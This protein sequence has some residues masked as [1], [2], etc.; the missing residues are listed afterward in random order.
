[1]DT[2]DRL[3]ANLGMLSSN[4]HELDKL[5]KIIDIEPLFM[6]AF[7]Q[8]CDK[9]VPKDI[10]S[11]ISHGFW[12]A[13]KINYRKMEEFGK[14]ISTILAFTK[15]LGVLTQCDLNGFGLNE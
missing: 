9:K 10:L 4:I 8:F 2:S 6:A 12:R 14:N 7:H 13:L 11:C 5:N 1:M 15:K 3:K